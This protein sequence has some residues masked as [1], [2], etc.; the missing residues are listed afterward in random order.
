[1]ISVFG[2]DIEFIQIVR[3]TICA[4]V[5]AT[6]LYGFGV[7]GCGSQRSLKKYLFSFLFFFVAMFPA[8]ILPADIRPFVQPPLTFLAFVL[9]LFIVLHQKG[10]LLLKNSFLII[11]FA[12]LADTLSGLILM[13]LLSPNEYQAL[14]QYKDPA[15]YLTNTTLSILA[16]IIIWIYSQFRHRSQKGHL[17]EKISLVLRPVAMIACLLA[18]FLQIMTKSKGMDSLTLTNRRRINSLPQR[19]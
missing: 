1:M 2:S 13:P 10:S 16:L 6:F 11:F 19:G 4:S 7:I 18:L 5:E 3:L 12:L 15:V 17:L 14:N 8:L 9:Y